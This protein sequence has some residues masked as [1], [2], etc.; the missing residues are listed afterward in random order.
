M[1]AL[2][3]AWRARGV[4]RTLCGERVFTMEVPAAGHQTLL[5]G[6]TVTGTVKLGGGFN[7]FLDEVRVWGSGRSGNQIAYEYDK[8][9]NSPWLP[10][11]QVINGVSTVITSI[12]HS[13]GNDGSLICN[14]RFDDGQNTTITNKIR[15]KPILLPDNRTRR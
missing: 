15:D 14:L 9:I 10:G 12:V 7:G 1:G 3:D 11:V 13:V 6:S 4:E 2:V 8:I 5:S